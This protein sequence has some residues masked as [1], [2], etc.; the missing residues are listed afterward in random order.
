MRFVCA[1][2]LDMPLRERQAEDVDGDR[3]VVQ[4]Y[5]GRELQLY[6]SCGL[7]ELICI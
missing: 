4:V 2:S 1:C 5:S 7:L 3:L 6:V